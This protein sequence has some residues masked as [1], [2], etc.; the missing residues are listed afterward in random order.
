MSIGPPALGN[1]LVQRLD[2]VLGTTMAASANLISGARPDAVTQPG[3]AAR[4]GQLGRNPRGLDQVVGRNGQPAVLDAK[5]AAALA[6]AARGTVTRNDTTSSAPTTLGS[7][8]RTILALLA[9]FPEQAPPIQGRAPLIMPQ[10][11]AAAGNPAAAQPQAA[12]APAPNANPAAQAPAPNAPAAEAAVLRGT[13]LPTGAGQAAHAQGAAPT[14][15]G[16]GQ[17]PA[18]L[19]QTLRAVLADSGIF[20]ESHLTEMVFGKRT[21]EQL[22]AEPQAR[23]AQAHE[24]AQSPEGQKATQAAQAARTATPLPP[25]APDLPDTTTSLLPQHSGLN[26]DSTALVRQ[27]LEALANQMVSWRGEAWPGAD[28][29]WEVQRDP[30]GEDQ[31][32]D[33][34]THWNTRLTL[35]LPRLGQVEARLS[36]AGSQLVLN[37]V[38]PQG[39]V[40]LNQQSE[41][42]RSKLGAAGLTLSNLTIDAMPPQLIMPPGLFPPFSPPFSF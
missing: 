40:E 33:P 42:L 10:G 15:A 35:E 23:L 32:G 19:A 18:Q 21:P 8:A 4:A 25:G 27:Q 2:A 1:V 22:R 38:A 11:Q 6:L 31:P 14:H 13:P 41:H 36:L 16:A 37:I 5:T 7:T 9:T 24:V 30:Y 34:A 12:P 26:P 20:Y 17:L 29:E 39:A 28:M 3:E